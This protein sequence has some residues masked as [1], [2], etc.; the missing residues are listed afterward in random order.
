MGGDLNGC[1]AGPDAAAVAEDIIEDIAAGWP[2]DPLPRYTAL[3]AQQSHHKAVA[4][5]LGNARAAVVAQMNYDG[6]SY[7]QIAG[8]IGL[9]RARVQQLVGK[10]RFLA[11]GGEFDLLVRPPHR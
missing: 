10:G 5:K 4:D 1:E 3:T 9:T 8:L 11:A 6:L 2:G 7:D